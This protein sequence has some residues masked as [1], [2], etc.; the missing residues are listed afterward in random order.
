MC[1]I[2]AGDLPSK[3]KK[4]GKINIPTPSSCFVTGN[5]RGT[6]TKIGTGLSTLV[7]TN[8]IR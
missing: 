5:N 2:P 4:W 7:T 6:S 8:N 3:T 1:S